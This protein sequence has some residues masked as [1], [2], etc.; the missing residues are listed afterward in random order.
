MG[1]L[2]LGNK[3]VIRVSLDRGDLWDERPSGKAEW[4]KEYTFAKGAE[5]VAQ[6]K[7][8]VVGQWWDMPY[9]GVTPTKLPGGRIEIVLPVSEVVKD[10]ELNLAIAEGRIHFNFPTVVRAIYNAT[11]PVEM[12]SNRKG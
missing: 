3:N 9:K 10:F 12:F 6:K 11:E 8:D 5:M 1:G 4:W 2:L 7:S